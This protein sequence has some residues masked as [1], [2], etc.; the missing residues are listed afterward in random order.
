[1][2]GFYKFRGLYC[3]SNNAELNGGAIN[4][5]HLYREI[6]LPYRFPLLQSTDFPSFRIYWSDL[7]ISE[8]LTSTMMLL[9]SSRALV[10]ASKLFVFN[11]EQKMALRVFYSIDFVAV[12]L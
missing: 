8:I 2:L 10:K 7:Q 1:M 5:T 9:N 3:K 4:L 6:G 11:K 12:G